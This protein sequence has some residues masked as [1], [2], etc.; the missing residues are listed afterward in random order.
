MKQETVTILSGISN[1]HKDFASYI[2][3]AF[4]RRIRTDLRA[5]L[6][7]LAHQYRTNEIDELTVEMV[8]DT[9][10]LL[11]HEEKIL[12]NGITSVSKETKSNLSEIEQQLFKDVLDS[13]YLT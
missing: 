12:H 9:D 3:A 1:T 8:A 2:E 4:D 7:N 13:D 5:E 6:V 11:P 10:S